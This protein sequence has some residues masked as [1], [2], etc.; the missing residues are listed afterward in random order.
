MSF[1]NRPVVAAKKAVTAPTQVI[2][3]R[4]VGANSSNGDDRSSKYTP[5]VT[6]VLYSYEYMTMSY[7]CIHRKLR[8]VDEVIPAS[9]LC[10]NIVN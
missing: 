6:R 8:I 1:C 9:W 3:T 4:V 10:I 2:T 5:A 7:S